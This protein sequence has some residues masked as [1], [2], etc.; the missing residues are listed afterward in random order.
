MV[1]AKVPPRR[2]CYCQIV[3]CVTIILPY[4]ATVWPS[5]H[6]V[7]IVWHCRPHAITPRPS[8]H[9]VSTMLRP[10]GHQI[11]VAQILPLLPY[12]VTIALP[13]CA[14]ALPSH[15]H[16]AHN[17]L[18]SREMSLPSRSHVPSHLCHATHIAIATTQPS[19]C[20][21]SYSLWPRGN[22]TKM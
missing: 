6:N 15:G 4:I 13:S 22:V 21:M 3:F 5:H 10:R 14:L 11:V 16:R 9:R 18:P 2:P 8:H 7:A 12:N 19:H 17:T 20:H 1:M